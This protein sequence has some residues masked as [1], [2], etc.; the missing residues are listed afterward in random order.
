[1]TG[2]ST[3]LFT[4]DELQGT[5]TPFVGGPSVA[6]DGKSYAYFTVTFSSLLFSV[7]G[8]R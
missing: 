1:V 5:A 3:S 4:V 6:D 7:A 8:M 2:R